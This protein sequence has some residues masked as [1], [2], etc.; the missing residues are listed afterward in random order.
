MDGT[1]S[2]AASKHAVDL[3]QDI[4]LPGS[5]EP[6]MAET[7]ESLSPISALNQTCALRGAGVGGTW[8]SHLGRGFLTGSGI[9]ERRRVDGS[10]SFYWWM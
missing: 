9:P 10:G 8:T 1:R 2:L 6:G 4:G 5:P 3:N 7:K